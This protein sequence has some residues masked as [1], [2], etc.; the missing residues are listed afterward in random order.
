MTYLAPLGILF[1]IFYLLSK[2]YVEIE[3]KTMVAILIAL[4]GW[5]IAVDNI[6][7]QINNSLKRNIEAEAIKQIDNALTG[8]SAALSSAVTY[9]NDFVV[10]PLEIPDNLYYEAASKKYFYIAEEISKMRKAS[11]D[12]YRVLEGNEIAVIH[13]EQY[14]RY[15]TI[16]IGDYIEHVESLNNSFLMSTSSWKLKE[17]KY[18]NEVAKFKPLQEEWATIACYCMDFRKMMQ[19]ELLGDIFKR[20]LKPRKPLPDYGKTLKEVATR[21][22]VQRLIDERNAKLDLPKGLA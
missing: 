21:E 12:L 16:M 13:L 11:G 3:S 9:S 7:L 6:F 20:E 22:E 8:I 4:I 17:K 19:N 2:G 18:Q 5:P 10:K 15:L 1:V 14:Y